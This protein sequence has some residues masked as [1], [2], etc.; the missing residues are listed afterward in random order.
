M[1]QTQI[2]A[3]NALAN[4]IGITLEAVLSK[5]RLGLKWCYGCQA[6]HERGVFG[7]DST[8]YD[9][10]VPACKDYRNVVQRKRYIPKENPPRVY[11]VSTM[12]EIKARFWSNVDKRGTDE[13][14]PWM[15]GRFLEGYGQFRVW[16]KHIKAHRFSYEITIGPIG[17]GLLACHTCD[18]P[19]CCNPKHIF[20]GT[21]ADNARDMTAKGRGYKGPRPSFPGELNPAAK[22]TFEKVEEIRRLHQHGMSQKRLAQQFLMSQSQVGNIIRGSS[23]RT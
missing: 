7:L 9:G 23:W 19:P 12:E 21:H 1:P 17:K 20:V 16:K 13:C 10:L 14:W 5:E 2:G 22:L 4:K 6:W 15:A 11:P 3:R 8:R 18:N